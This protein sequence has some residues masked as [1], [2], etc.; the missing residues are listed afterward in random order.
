MFP[1]PRQSMH[2]TGASPSPSAPAGLQ[3][4]APPA[5]AARPATAWAECVGCSGTADLER[6]LQQ[7]DR[8]AVRY[9]ALL[10][11]AVAAVTEA[12]TA[13]YAADRHTGPGCGGAEL[14]LDEVRGRLRPVGEHALEEAA[15]LQPQVEQRAEL[16]AR[17]WAKRAAPKGKETLESAQAMILA[18]TKVLLPHLPALQAL[19]PGRRSPAEAAAVQLLER[20]DPGRASGPQPA[21]SARLPAECSSSSATRASAREREEAQLPQAAAATSSAPREAS[22]CLSSGPPR[23]R[24]RRRAGA[25]RRSARRE[26]RPAECAPLEEAADRRASA[27]PYVLSSDDEG[28]AEQGSTSTQLE[29]PVTEVFP[30]FEAF[31]G[32]AGYGNFGSPVSMQEPAPEASPRDRWADPLN[33]RNE[34]R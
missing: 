18:L 34:R 31:P 15:R 32:E 1:A 11:A 14:I 4:P 24:P 23:E 9:R 19:E 33:S 22:P 12:K 13:L 5:H 17:L 20:V 27:Y 29:P 2:S 3:L 26:P 21:T 6:R 7:A 16:M 28:L 25:P 8:C 30:G 10:Q